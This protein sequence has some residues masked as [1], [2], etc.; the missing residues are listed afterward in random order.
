[1]RRMRPEGAPL[2]ESRSRRE[3]GSSVTL[4]LSSSLLP[5]AGGE[6]R[7]RGAIAALAFLLLAIPALLRAQSMDPPPSGMVPANQKPEILKEIGIDQR[8][9]APLPLDAPL[10]DEAGRAVRLGD[11]FGKRPVVFALVYYNCPMLC[12]QVLNGLVGALNTMSLDA[13]RDFDVVALSF[14]TRD[15]ASDAAAKKDAYLTRYKRPN[16]SEGWHFLTGD[17]PS[18]ERVTKAAGF[19]F[20]WDEARGQF[21]HAS[22]IMVATPDG[23]LARYFYGIEYAPRDLRLGLVEASAGRIGTPVDQVLLYCFHYDPAS[24]KYGAVVIRMIRLAGIATLVAL[25]ASIWLMSRR[26]ARHLRAAPGEAR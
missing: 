3:R 18:I 12:T 26:R 1:M 14:D 5:P 9:D 19:R 4:S 16:A 25:G 17:A 8:L 2:D 7:P 20:K 13:G 24:G 21:A 22:A 23:R 11:Y 15:K 6:G 10:R